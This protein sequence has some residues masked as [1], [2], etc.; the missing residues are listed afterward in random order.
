M[1]FAYAMK[2]IFTIAA[3]RRET[4]EWKWPALQ[5]A[6]MCALAYAGAFVAVHLTH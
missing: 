4:G 2:S 1:F 3:V 6:C 5:F